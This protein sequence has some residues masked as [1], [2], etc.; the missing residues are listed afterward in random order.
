MGV[1]GDL[2]AKPFNR[3]GRVT[4][5]YWCFAYNLS[6]VKAVNFGCWPMFL[7]R[8]ALACSFVALPAMARA[9]AFEQITIK[10]VRSANPRSMRLQVL[11]DGE[12]LA[13]AVLVID[14]ISY[15]YDVPSNPSPR[16]NAL[17]D[18]IY[19]DRYDIEAKAS[20]HAITTTSQD[21][22]TQ[23]RVKQMI[24]RL[25]ADRFSLVM[26]VARE[27]MSTY[28]MTVASSG[29]PLQRSAITAKDCIFDTAPEGCRTFVIGFGHPL[30]ANA[31][32]M[33]DLAHYI[34]NWTDLPPVNRT[35]L[36]GLFTVRTEGWLPMRLPPPP[37]D[38]NGHVDFSILPTI[39]TVL[40][41]LGLELHR[42]E[43]VLP[44]YTIER[45]ERAA[46][47]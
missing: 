23:L 24:R 46:A 20:P 39:F 34:E 29:P 3:H 1:S 22:E 41:K 25:L 42:Q 33:D 7:F 14:L 37:P 21:G 31:I 28:A 30:N 15:A 43:E 5:V 38:G 16:L 32:S 11:P 10:A 35:N 6:D 13:H 12:L 40:G 8:R 27:R 4:R 47:N 9:Q 19:G 17:P 2:S 44:V 36:S 26:R 18:W 45:I